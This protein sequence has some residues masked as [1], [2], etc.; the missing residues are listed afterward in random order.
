MT[1]PTEEDFNPMKECS[2]C[3]GSGFMYVDTSSSCTVMRGECCGGCG[4]NTA[5]DSCN[6]EGEIEMT[7]EEVY[8]ERLNHEEDLSEDRRHEK[9]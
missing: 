6:G 7:D 4:Y 1:D 9:Y 3:S 8:E 5:C 2:E